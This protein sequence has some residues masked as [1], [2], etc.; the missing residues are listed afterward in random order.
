MPTVVQRD[1]KKIRPEQE[2]KDVSL[3]SKQG[4]LLGFTTSV[5]QTNLLRSSL[6]LLSEISILGNMSVVNSSRCYASSVTKYVSH[7]ISHGFIFLKNVQL[8]VKL[9]AR[10]SPWTPH[11]SKDSKWCKLLS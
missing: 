6:V 2:S 5:G 9:T 10:S 11:F 1:C 8:E 7:G 3:S 4:M